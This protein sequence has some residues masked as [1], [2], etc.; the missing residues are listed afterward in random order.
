MVDVY[1]LFLDEPDLV[2]VTFSVDPETDTPEV[3]KQYQNSYKIQNKNW[4]FLTGNAESIYR[5]ARQ[6][7]YISGFYDVDNQDFVHSEKVIL[8]DKS[9]IIRGYY[10]ATDKEEVERLKT[11]I[12][13]LK[14]EYEQQQEN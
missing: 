9:G 14:K 12:K 8:V 2:F 3:M 6:G 5:L 1:S 10:D 4:S 11:E 13:V 7:F